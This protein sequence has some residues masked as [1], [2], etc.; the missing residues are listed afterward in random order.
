MTEGFFLLAAAVTA[1]VGLAGMGGVLGTRAR[2]AARWRRSLVA[3]RLKFPRGLDPAAAGGFLAGLSG[4]SARRRVRP[5]AAGGVVFEVSANKRR[6]LKLGVRLISAKE[7]FGE[8][9][10]A[11]A[12][13][14]MTDIFNEVQVRLNGQD[15]KTKMHNRARNGG[16]ISRAKVGYLNVRKRI[17]GAEVRTVE[18]DPERASL[19]TSAFE[20]F[21]TGRFTVETL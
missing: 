2:S 11:D 5:F 17:D 19:M 10:M 14:A 4:L 6:L 20:W 18:R 16:T 12:M 3:Y 8:G 1:L 21:A 15:I 13:E 9:I 7:N